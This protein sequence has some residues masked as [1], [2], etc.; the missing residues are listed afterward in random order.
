[1]KDINPIHSSLKRKIKKA[2][3]RIPKLEEELKGL[4]EKNTLEKL[5]EYQKPIKKDK[6]TKP[7]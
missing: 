6:K 2:E 5:A 3:E 4:Q 7:E 1:M